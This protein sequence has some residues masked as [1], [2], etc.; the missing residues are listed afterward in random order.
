MGFPFFAVCSSNGKLVISADAILKKGTPNLSKKSILS[1][2]HPE[3]AKS[4]LFLFE[5]SNKL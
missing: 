1:S 2:S 3:A 4:I 5:K